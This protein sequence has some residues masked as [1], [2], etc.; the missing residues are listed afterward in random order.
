MKTVQ[1]MNHP[2]ERK[3]TLTPLEK[4]VISF[5]STVMFAMVAWVT[6]TTNKTA[7][8][9]AIMQNSLEYIKR[10]AEAAGMDRF[11]GS[12]GR[13]HERRIAALEKL[14]ERQ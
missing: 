9:V 11:T 2:Q 1:D 3:L 5:F 10:D 13:E 8:E 4:G 6:V 12:Q 7:T 14:H